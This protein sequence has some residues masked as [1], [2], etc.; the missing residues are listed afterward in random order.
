MKPLHR[1]LRRL[2]RRED[3]NVTVEFTVV[4]PLVLM[5]FMASVEAGFFMIKHV[6]LERGLDILMRDFRLGRMATL[7]HDQIRD[8]VCDLTPVMTNCNASLK[9]WIEPLNTTTWAAP[10]AY[11]GDK[12]GTL[13]ANTTGSVTHGAPDQVMYVRVCLLQQPM[14]PSTGMGL[15][16]RADSIGR[17]YEIAATTI[18]VN[19]PR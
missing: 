17:G 19:E 18:V 12:N 1:A 6:M 10:D 4:I 11:C 5:I 2:W 9:V 16:L 7:N 3:G 15:K 14:F 13:E 8:R